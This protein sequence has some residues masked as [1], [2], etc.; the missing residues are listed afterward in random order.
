MS[1][2]LYPQGEAPDIV[3]SKAFEVALKAMDY[4]QEPR[5]Y[6]VLHEWMKEVRTGKRSRDLKGFNHS[7]YAFYE[8]S[9][10]DALRQI[11]VSAVIVKRPWWV[12]IK[13]KRGFRYRR[14]LQILLCVE[15]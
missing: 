2:D 12:C 4:R 3:Y 14:Y 13:L 8:I 6:G 7:G 11:N 1:D 15:V 10:T 5:V 9:K